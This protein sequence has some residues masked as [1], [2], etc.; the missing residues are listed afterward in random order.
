MEPHQTPQFQSQIP[1]QPQPHQQ[2]PLQHDSNGHHQSVSHELTVMQEGERR[3]LEIKRHPFG[4][5]VVYFMCGLVIVLVAFITL[6]V[7]PGISS[8]I[9]ASQANAIAG[10]SLLIVATLTAVY[11][12][13]ATKIYWGNSWVLTSDSITQ[14]D[15]TGLFTRKS[16]Q[17][18]LGNIEDVSAAQNGIVSHLFG[19]GVLKVETAGEHSKF[20]FYFCPNPNYYAQQILKA[21]EE[22]ALSHRGGGHH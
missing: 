16:S 20:H 13:I 21:R 2:Q 8:S 22:F 3:I 17:L 19:Y 18:A 7:L 11:S 10:I 14:I 1:E 4:I 12:L 9:S 6:A 5:L 15:Q